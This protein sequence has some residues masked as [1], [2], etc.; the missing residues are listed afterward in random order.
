MT[1]SGFALKR[2]SVWGLNGSVTLDACGVT[3]E[4]DSGPKTVI[5]YADVEGARVSRGTEHT[6][7][8][9]L[10]RGAPATGDDGIVLGIAQERA[11]ETL[12]AELLRRAFS[13]RRSMAPL[14]A[15]CPSR[16]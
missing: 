2:Y 13:T 16:A 10:S 9:V 12:R 4:R 14:N 6:T 8:V 11:V 5:A 7:F 3:L 15:S 1:T